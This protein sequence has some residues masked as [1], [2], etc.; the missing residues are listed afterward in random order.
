MM[1][2]GDGLMSSVSDCRLHELLLPHMSLSLRRQQFCSGVGAVTR[3]GVEELVLLRGSC[4]HAGHMPLPV[5]RA[6]CD[7]W[8]DVNN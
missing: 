2:A 7:V 1:D 6:P 5:A 3:E 8:G 4:M